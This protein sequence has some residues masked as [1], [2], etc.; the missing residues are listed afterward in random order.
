MACDYGQGFLFSRPLPAQG[1]DTLFANL[2]VSTL[3]IPQVVYRPDVIP[4]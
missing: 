4:A 1:I 2:L 3:P